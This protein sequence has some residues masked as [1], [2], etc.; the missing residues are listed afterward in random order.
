MSD[1]PSKEFSTLEAVAFLG[2]MI[3]VQLSS[4]LFAQ[5]GTY[6]YSPSVGTGRVV[7]VSMAAVWIIFTIGRVFDIVTD[8][9]IGVWS[10]RTR[11]EGGRRLLPIKGRRRPFIFWGSLLMTVSAVSFWY[12]PVPEESWTNLLYGAIVM[13]AHWGFYT[14]AYVPLLALAPEIARSKQGRVKLGT[15]I[16][17]GMTLGLAMAVVMP[18]ILIKLLDPARQVASQQAEPRYSPAG[19]QRVAILFAFVSLALF[20]FHVWTVKERQTVEQPERTVTPFGEM[21]Q[22]MRNPVFRLYFFILALFYVGYLSVQR[23]LPYWAELGLGGDEETVTVLAIPF[24]LTCLGSALIT[25]WLTRRIELKWLLVFCLMLIT[26]D[27]PFMYV[28][29]RLDV[30]PEVRIRLGMVLFGLAGVGQGLVYVLITPLLGEIID[31]DAAKTGRRREALYNGLHGVMVKVALVLA[32]VIATQTMQRFG[33]SMDD[34]TGVLI[35]GPIGGVFALLGLILA[36]RYPVLNP[37]RRNR[38]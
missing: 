37:I 23:A 32:I 8:P 17:V 34:P 31:L 12:P 20:Q 19:Y 28:I 14:V 38:P 16:A 24:M 1:G 13:S 5:W 15:W 9:L 29:G 6:F 18:G 7:Y 25:P 21:L 35:I 26:I 4:E 36:L 30:A 27:L 10:D 2:A 22:G 3:A 11:P 33:N